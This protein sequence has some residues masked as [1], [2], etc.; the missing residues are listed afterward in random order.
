[1]SRHRDPHRRDPRPRDLAELEATRDLV[2]EIL[3][4]A[5][6]IDDIVA[7]L[8]EEIPADAHPGEDDTIVLLQMVIGS[9]LPAT[10]AAGPTA[11]RTAPPSSPRSANAPSPTSTAPPT[12]PATPSD[13][14]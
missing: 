8:L 11:L 5:M 1:M 4:T 7:A 14:G 12:S 3:L 2:E 13:P 10:R 9:A 6:A